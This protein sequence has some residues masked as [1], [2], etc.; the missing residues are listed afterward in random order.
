MALSPVAVY[1]LVVCRGV[2]S[3]PSLCFTKQKRRPPTFTYGD[4][5]DPCA[6]LQEANLDCFISRPRDVPGR[7]PLS[8][9][10]IWGV[11]VAGWQKGGT[12]R[13]DQFGTGTKQAI[14]LFTLLWAP[15]IEAKG[16]KAGSGARWCCIARRKP[17]LFPGVDL[18]PRLT[19]SWHGLV[20]RQLSLQSAFERRCPNWL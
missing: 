6:V 10:A 11:L 20:A 12:A 14:A 7:R 3:I 15:L 13:P 2:R 9:A 5:G 16:Q 18:R 17:L 19:G 4:A 1:W 8:I